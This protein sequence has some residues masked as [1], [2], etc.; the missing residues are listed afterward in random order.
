MTSPTSPALQAADFGTRFSAFV[1]DA[2]ALFA[3]Q[4]V[5]V[6]VASRQLQA[7]GMTQL[8]QCNDEAENAAGEPILACEGPSTTLWAILLV[9][10]VVSTIGYYAW[11]EGKYRATPGKRL[12][13]LHVIGT[14]GN[15]PIGM[16]TGLV[17]AVVRQLF[18]LSLFVLLDPS[19]ASLSVP[20][21]VFLAIPAL[22]LAGLA[23]G[24]YSPDGRALHDLIANT[25]VVRGEETPAIIPPITRSTADAAEHPQEES[26]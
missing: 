9:F 1:I 16:A 6:I 10:L 5:V 3:V 20:P 15:A 12:M 2:A 18:W 7:I 24:A 23:W 21:I 17:R 19:P 14:D 8:I 13:G 25:V 22:A 26:A 11:F 4:W